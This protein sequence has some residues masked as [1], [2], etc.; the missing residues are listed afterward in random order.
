MEFLR[1]AKEIEKKGELFYRELANEYEVQEM[2][3]IFRFLAEEE[4]RHYAIFDAMETKTAV[5]ELTDTNLTQDTQKIFDT[6]FSQFRSKTEP[7]IDRSAIMDKALALETKSV[8][9]YE[10]EYEKSKSME[11]DESERA[12]LKKII[13]QEKSHIDFISSLKDFYRHPGEWLE[14]A[15]WYHLDTY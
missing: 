10:K 4:S 11:L 14:N 8:Q 2:A 12:I 13:K 15:E 9:F 5:P 6:F 3:G 7:I 1:I